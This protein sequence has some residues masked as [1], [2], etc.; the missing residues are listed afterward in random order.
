MFWW[1]EFS[2]IQVIV[3]QGNQEGIEGRERGGWG[4]R[5]GEINKSSGTKDN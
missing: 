2:E 5:D 3:S 4:G 1:D